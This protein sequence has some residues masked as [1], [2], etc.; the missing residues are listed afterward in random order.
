[1]RNAVAKLSWVRS[2]TLARLLSVEARAIDGRVMIEAQRG[3]E[4]IPRLVEAL[5]DGSLRSV[6][7]HPPTLAD[8]FAKLTGKVLS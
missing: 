7:M 8:A 5:P 6:N 1:M 4:L 2:T 3:H